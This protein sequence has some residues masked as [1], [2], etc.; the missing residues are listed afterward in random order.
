MI[1]MRQLSEQPSSPDRLRMAE[2][3]AAFSLATDLGMIQP[4]GHVLRACYIA[5]CIAQELRLSTPEQTVLYYATLLMH[6]GC[7]ASASALAALFAAD[8]QEIGRELH[9]VDPNNP[10]GMLGWMIRNIAPDLPLPARVSHMLQ[11]MTQASQ[12]KTDGQRATCEVGARMARRLGMPTEVQETL[13]NLYERWDGK[14]FN[15]LAGNAIPIAARIVDPASMI[16]IYFASRGPRQAEEYVHQGQG[17]L[18]DPNVAAAFLSVAKRAVFWETLQRED[19]KDIIIDLE[20]DNPLRHLDERKLDEVVLAFADF[21]DIKSITTLGHSKGTAQY[22]EA[23]AVR[24]G[25]SQKDVNEV[26]RA[27]LLH[28]L[29]HVAV[30]SYILDKQTPLTEAERERQRLHPYYSE[31]IL[32]T[33]PALRP[34]ATLAGA[35]HEWMNGKGYYR[36]LSGK[37]IPLAAS[38][39]APDFPRF[40]ANPKEYRKPISRVLV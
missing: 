4:M 15:K 9:L 37:D 1:P 40:H 13:R 34:L 28:D 36:G 39:N 14:G 30:G 17:T 6:S 27:A 5:M 25:L 35:H 18:L 16:E 21:A 38:G 8:E 32:A 20:P 22:A 11:A 29:G 19:L 33:V 24:M 31:R 10:L 26:R 3:L 2:I 23:M 7:T 12:V